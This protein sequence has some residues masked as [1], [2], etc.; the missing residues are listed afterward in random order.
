MADKKRARSRSPPGCSGRS[1]A[2]RTE[3]AVW[4]LREIARGYNMR[5]AAWDGR[6]V[7]VTAV[8][9]KV[10]TKMTS[11]CLLHKVEVTEET[12]DRMTLLVWGD[13]GRMVDHAK[14][15]ARGD[16]I[17]FCRVK[18]SY[19]SYE[20]AVELK[21]CGDSSCRTFSAAK[22]QFSTPRALEL[23]SWVATTSFLP[24]RGGPVHPW[25]TLEA[26]RG[27]AGDSRE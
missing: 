19:S 16:V 11:K 2:A 15:M 21:S 3:P 27:G 13:K 9:S 1:T 10:D 6:V 23:L 7:D 22:P 24:G 17:L 20:Q 8:V 12:G 25:R 4:S 14:R 18:V 5:K 26:R